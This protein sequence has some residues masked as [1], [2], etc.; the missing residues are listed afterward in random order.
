MTGNIWDSLIILFVT[1]V[2]VI[3]YW[4]YLSPQFVDKFMARIEQTG[5]FLIFKIP[6]RLKYKYIV[7]TSEVVFLL[8]MLLTLLAS[9][10]GE[11]AYLFIY[12]CIVYFFA[13]VARL[14]R[15]TFPDFPS[16][17][18]N[19]EKNKVSSFAYLI[20][21]EFMGMI[22]WVIPVAIV[23][24]VYFHLEWP[25]YILFL[26]FLIF[27]VS[28]NLWIY[29]PS[30]DIKKENIEARKLVTYCTLCLL[31]IMDAYLKFEWIVGVTLA[32][33]EIP[34]F[35]FIQVTVLFIAIERVVKSVND[36]KKNFLSKD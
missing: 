24:V 9:L 8:I 11:I 34:Q 10:F 19:L 32:G 3:F 29:F 18:K 25:N 26:G 35:Y 23:V 22:F 28:F 16:I 31:V 13:T 15:K 2:I 17:I 12:Q 30:K 36:Y 5:W 6:E 21:N 27:P 1:I 14:L 4:F 33:N 7:I 20:I